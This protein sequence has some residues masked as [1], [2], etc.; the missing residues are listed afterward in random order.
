[1]RASTPDE[2][3]MLCMFLY[4]D[5][6]LVAKMSSVQCVWVSTPRDLAKHLY[7][8]RF[9]RTASLLKMGAG[10]REEEEAVLNHIF[11]RVV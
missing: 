9:L 4:F 8:V 11:F 1:M 2:R 6:P 3:I 10:E 7:L 5:V